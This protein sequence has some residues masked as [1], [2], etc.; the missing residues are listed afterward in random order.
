MKLLVEKS[1][2]YGGLSYD[3]NKKIF[4][5]FFLLQFF[6]ANSFGQLWYI[7]RGLS[8]DEVAW[9]IDV[10]SAGNI[11][12]AVEEKNQ[13][14]YW[15]FNIFLFKINSNGQQIWQSSPFGWTYN[16]IAFVVKVEG[17][18]VFLAGRTDSTLYPDSGDA[19][20]LS[21]D[22]INGGFEWQY[23]Y[24][25]VPDYGYEEIDGLMVQPDGIYFSGWTKGQTTDEDFLV[26]KISLTGQLVWTNAWDYNHQFDG[27]NGHMAMDN[28]FLYT[29]GHT[30]LLNGSL[31]CFS[32]TNGAYQWD[33]TWSG[34][35]ND[36]ALGLTMSAD[37]MLY[38]VGYF[39]SS[40]YGSQT[41]LEK[42]TRTGQLQWTHIWGGTGSEDSR[43]L[44]TDGDSIIYVVGTTTSYGSG[45]KDI[46]ILKYDSAGTLIDSLLWGGMY[47]EV[48]KDVVMYG[49]YLYITGETQSYGNG[50]INGDHKEDGLLLKVNGRTM[51][52]PDS[53]MTNISSPLLYVQNA[54]EIY[55][56]PSNGT[57]RLSLSDG[58]LG[59]NYELK[60]F[61]V[62]GRIVKQAGNI[63]DDQQ[64]DCSNLNN[65]LYLLQL[66]KND[67]VIGQKKIIK[68]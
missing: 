28:N 6:A 20:V 48:A 7:T 10:D 36:E 27:A 25:P 52:A 57:F 22:L 16:D 56:N 37:S 53:S 61:D 39:G 38:V 49:D 23:I 24:N 59:K 18:N 26:Q 43:A 34:S 44:V 68:Q 32:R 11:Y 45:G 2:D 60:I 17:Q 33:V 64:I 30:N 42:F 5:L 50:N 55:P 12:W 46:F 47:D 62:F 51:Q 54:I 14:P 1:Q 41:C 35:G 8:T 40:Q 58:K 13:W 31:V 67:I 29:A 21:Y 19:L 15:Y 65:G 9:G 3:M 4:I 66:R 63:T